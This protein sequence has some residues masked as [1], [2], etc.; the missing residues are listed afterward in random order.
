MLF[1]AYSLFSLRRQQRIS[2]SHQWAVEAFTSV[3]SRGTQ[4]HGQLRHSHQ[5]VADVPSLRHTQDAQGRA[6]EESDCRI[7]PCLPSR[8]TL[9]KYVP[10]LASLLRGQAFF[11]ETLPVYGKSIS[12]MYDIHVFR[13]ISQATSKL[14]DWHGIPGG[15]A[16]VF[17][18]PTA[19]SKWLGEFLQL[20]QITLGWFRSTLGYKNDST[21]L[22]R[23]LGQQR[24]SSGTTEAFFC[25]HKCDL[26]AKA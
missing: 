18:C 20:F 21:W 5:W 17:F 23:M 14:W 25:D 3:R 7:S 6:L 16:K 19:F 24:R 22:G 8:Q 12:R 26:L 13:A 2:H 15:R 10:V 4:T 9:V 11:I 1:I